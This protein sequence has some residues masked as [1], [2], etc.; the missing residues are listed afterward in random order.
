M[1]K[2]LYRFSDALPV[3]LALAIPV[4]LIPQS[5]AQALNFR[6]DFGGNVSDDFQQAAQE[7][8]G[9]WSSVLKDDVA[10]DIRVE[11]SDLSSAGAVLAGARPNKVKVKYEDYVQAMLKDAVSSNDIQALGSL[12]LSSKGQEA[13]QEFQAGA[14]SSVEKIKLDSKEF[15]F[16]MDGQ[17]AKGA[18]PSQADFIDNNGNDNNKSVMLTRAQAQALGLV[19]TKKEGLDGI[20]KINSDVSWDTDSSNGIDSDK[21]DLSTVLKHEIGHTLGIISGVDGLDFLLAVNEPVDIEKNEFSYLTPLDMFRYSE[22]S[23]ALGVMD[24]TLGSDEKYFSLDA[25]QSAVTNAAGRAAYFS[26]GSTESGGDGY[27]GSHWKS[28]GSPLGVT[29]PILQKGT[30]IDISE[31]DLALLD[32]VGWDLEDNNL[33]RA[34]A[35]GFD[36]AGLKNDLA[37]DRQAVKSQIIAE[38]GDD[39][40]ALDAALSEASFETEEKFRQKLQEEFDKLAKELEGEDGGKDRNKK[41]SKFYEKV[42]EEASKRNETL[43]KLPEEISKTDEKVREWLTLSTDDL[44]KEVRE[45]D[46]AT[47]NRLANI[48]KAAPR[49]ER[50]RME[51]KLEEALAQFVDKP[52]KLVGELLKSSGP[53][54]PVRWGR[55]YRFNW[56]F[57][58]ADPAELGVATSEGTDSLTYFATAAPDD[59]GII[60][61]VGA[62]AEAIGG[63]VPVGAGSLSAGGFS[64]SKRDAED[65]PEPSSVLALFGIA[66][67]GA[68]LTGQ[69]K[70]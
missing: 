11:Y 51:A 43:R 5:S 66:V 29:N 31:L 46:G 33:K 37:S 27:S 47:I 34:A 49:K 13:I 19:D 8:A 54:N 62:D 10:V 35:I 2:P 48:I 52:S 23:A 26:T 50:S 40:P 3:A 56:W 39:I 14:L 59:A 67:L 44:S 20:I 42:D 38:W 30:S 55:A 9:M 4:A 28:G 36:W 63:L 22:K 68:K 16:L 41:I 21:Y 45:A 69:R 6:F 53:S 60:D 7:A 25:G 17:F 61:R 70:A 18:S 24:L 1:S 32:A 57:Q 58:E 15:D 64:D 65:V 12:Q